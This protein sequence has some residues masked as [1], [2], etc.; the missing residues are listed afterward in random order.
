M[1]KFFK[2]NW[3]LLSAFLISLVMFFPSLFKFYTHDDF[4]FLKIANT[5]SISG[6][7]NFFNL[8][9]DTEGIGVYR[10]L[11]L[12]VYYFLGSNLFNFNP[13]PLRIISF[14]TFFAIIFLVGKLA[15]LLTGNAKIG[16]LSSFL[17]A[18]SVTHFGQLYY[19]GAFQE[20]F[21]TM[22]FLAS[23]IFFVKYEIDTKAKHSSR[24]LILSFLF[25]ILTLM[26]KETGVVL[27]VIF[28]L[29]HF[30]LKITRQAKVSIKKLMF[31]LLP[32]AATLI[33]YLTLHFFSFGLIKGD[34]YVW[35]FSIKRAV[36]TAVWYFLWSLNLPEMLIDFIGPGIHLNPNLLKYWSKDIVPIFVLFV[37][38]TSLAVYAFFKSKIL[39][40]THVILFS[41]S[42]FLVTL[43][44]IVF[45]P[46]HKFTYYLTLPLIGVVFLLSYMFL[47]IKSKT[48]I[49]F[50]IVWLSVSAV[51]LRL[52]VETNWITRGV[53]TS[54]R[55]Y[56][57]FEENR[58]ALA[59]KNIVF[60]DTPEDETLPWSPTETLKTVLSGN[61]FFEVFY[62][63]LSSRVS[64][65]GKGDIEIKSRKF[66]GY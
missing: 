19:I 58:L 48:S 26:S 45:L 47:N 18:V 39:K 32:Y 43:S 10:P 35:D 61:N 56:T 33:I 60:V 66:L 38:Q 62:P 5:H 24:N 64:Y 14:I 6:F 41:I 50:C 15:K 57:Y 11:T 17:Y 49:L 30:Y 34:S 20:L 36:N 3:Q 22:L 52:T 29:T 46:L 63:D 44:P 42:W 28:V 27:P 2:R 59:S 4:Y 7:L 53:D 55:V 51:S 16:V 54:K 65:S 21:L 12:R 9:K 31:F 8:V 25:F 40:N 13:I 37:I 23:V 1:I